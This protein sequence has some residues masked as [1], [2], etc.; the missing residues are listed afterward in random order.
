M[1]IRPASIIWI[2]TLGFQ[3][4]SYKEEGCSKDAY[5]DTDV[6]ETLSD[7]FDMENL[8]EVGIPYIVDKIRY[9]QVW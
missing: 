7:T 5:V 3:E 9:D 1:V 4:G 2:R 6:Q 8:N